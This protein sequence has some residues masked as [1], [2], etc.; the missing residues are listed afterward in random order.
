MVCVHLL[1][2]LRT[3]LW[4]NHFSLCHRNDSNHSQSTTIAGES[5]VSKGASIWEQKLNLS[6]ISALHHFVWIYAAV[7]G[8]FLF[9]CLQISVFCVSCINVPSADVTFLCFWC[10]QG[11][12]WTCLLQLDEKW[13]LQMTDFFIPVGRFSLYVVSL[14]HHVIA[15]WFIKCRLAFR[16]EFVNCITR[17]SPNSSVQYSL[18]WLIKWTEGLS[19]ISYSVTWKCVLR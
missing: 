17:V 14:A 3:V 12:N 16:R 13:D 6:G 5:L 18:K 9:A 1:S 10:R 8:F 19:D 4:H 11:M 15:M 7:L 2:I